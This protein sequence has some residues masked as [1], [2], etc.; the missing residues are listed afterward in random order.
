MSRTKS[1]S[2]LLAFSLVAYAHGAQNGTCSM[3][4]GR[5]ADYSCPTGYDLMLAGGGSDDCSGACYQS[6]NSVALKRVI[7]GAMQFTYHTRITDEQATAAA[8]DFIKTGTVSL[9]TAQG[10]QVSLRKSRRELE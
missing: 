5:K 2:A 9:K 6:G 3:D 1:C 4:D 8:N 7:T 10:K